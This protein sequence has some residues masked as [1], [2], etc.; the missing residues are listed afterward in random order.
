MGHS[1]GDLVSTITNTSNDGSGRRLEAQTC[2]GLG[3]V[4]VS[5]CTLSST[6]LRLLMSIM[7]SFLCVDHISLSKVV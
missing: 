3:V 1:K 7:Y 6:L 4:M 2:G 5:R